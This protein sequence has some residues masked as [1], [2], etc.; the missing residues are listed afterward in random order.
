MDLIL[1][2]FLLGL[3][4][5]FSGSETAFFS[6]EQSE[7]A[8][9]ERSAGRSGRHVIGLVRRATELLSGLLIGN[10]LV[11]TA[12]SV[13]ATS[14]CLEWWGVQ[15]LAVAIPAV[16][17]TLL[18]LGEITPKMLAL[19]FRYPVARLAQRPV[20]L[21]L[22]LVGP[23][24]RV[25]GSLMAW[26][27]RR[28]PFERTGT[29]P[30]TTEELQLACDLAVED[31]TLTETEGRSLGRLLLLDELEVRRVMTPRTSVVTLHRN[32]TLAQVL[33]VARRAGF[34]RYPVMESDSDMPVGFFH[35][36]DLLRERPDRELPLQGELRSLLY[37]PESK[38]VA[39]LLS[40]MRR[41]GFH[42]A[43]VVDEH[44]DFAGIVTMA[45][46]LQALLGPVMDSPA[47][48][49]QPTIPL[50]DGRWLISGRTDLREL[51]EATGLVLPPSR[52]YLTVAGFLMA[53]LGRVLRPGD[54][55]TLPEGRISVL[56][57]TG[58]RV[59]SLQVT[60]LRAGRPVGNGNG[61][62]R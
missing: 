58:L 42:L 6:L 18:L 5:S 60:L 12:A 1:L 53:K 43:G 50:G 49:D 27:L 61:G 3:S 57:M 55:V 54:R 11:N 24:I 17:L 9:L 38:D 13:M 23:V 56:E 16:T 7:L 30:L 28:L 21:W 26:L 37:V 14:I 34:N 36:K 35:L 59:D 15:G 62:E 10:L 4:A 40:V 44:G 8:R 2:L 31:G 46:C 48:G 19:R 47:G 22:W 52:D 45:D 29:R 33:A 39:A 20:R 41:D 25:I 51:Q 32:D